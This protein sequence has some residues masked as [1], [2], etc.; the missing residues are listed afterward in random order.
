M[1]K[2]QLLTLALA[3]LLADKH[4]RGTARFDD[5]PR[6]RANLC[7]AL[8]KKIQY[9][10]RWAPLKAVPFDFLLVQIHRIILATVE[11]RKGNCS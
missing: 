10:A 4:C 6:G 8:T 9:T 1:E 2:T 5:S 3:A 7:S 11:S